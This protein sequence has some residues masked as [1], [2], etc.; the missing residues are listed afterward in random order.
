MSDYDIITAII[1]VATIVIGLI[2]VIKPILWIIRKNKL[3]KMYES[4]STDN[5][6]KILASGLDNVERRIIAKILQER[7]EQK[8]I[9][10]RICLT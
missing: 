5:L 6:E 1:I 9:H 2:L 3:R 4:M 8:K 7:Y 10:L